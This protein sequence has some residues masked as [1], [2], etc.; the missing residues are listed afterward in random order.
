MKTLFYIEPHPIRNSLVGFRS[1]AQRYLPLIFSVPY[2]HEVRMFANRA[3]Y[4]TIDGD[5]RLH[6]DKLLSTSIKEESYLEQNLKSW[7]SN[8]CKEWVDLMEGK[9]KHCDFQINLLNRLYRSFQFDAIVH[10]GENGAITKFVED[11]PITRVAMEL[12]CSRNPFFNSIVMDPYG[13]N[14]SALLTKLEI[15]DIRTAVNNTQLSA[16]EARFGYTPSPFSKEYEDLRKVTKNVKKIAFLPLQVFDDANLLRFS[17][18]NKLSEVVLD[19]VPKLSDKGYVTIIKPHPSSK[20]RPGSFQENAIARKALDPW[21]KSIIW[22]NEE[23]RITNPEF[24]S[25]SDI[26][27]TV[28]SSVGFEALYFDKTVTVLGDAVYKPKDVFPSLEESMSGNFDHKKYLDHIGLIR[29]FV[30]N[31]YLQ[32]HAL[33]TNPR[34]FFQKLKWV[35]QAWKNSNGIPSKYIQE[36]YNK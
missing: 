17:K 15:E 13:T 28:N 35:D 22:C 4:S 2:G 34:A 5:V 31:G 6:F 11:K 18:Y 27:V 26:V 1:V 12:G 14:G 8:G 30:L 33:C 10:W 20:Y 16:E 23:T 25:L 9:G 21:N 3:T 36:F 32:N 19:I 24:Y 7:D 29:Q